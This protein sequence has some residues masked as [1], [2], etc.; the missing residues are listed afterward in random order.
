MFT[1][2]SSTKILTALEN[3]IK[4]SFLLTA[5]D[6]VVNICRNFEQK[7]AEKSVKKSFISKN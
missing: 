7:L 3:E 1:V 5:N 4:V 2:A 6:R